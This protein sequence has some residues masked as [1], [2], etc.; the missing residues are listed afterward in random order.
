MP[1][2]GL[3]GVRATRT[4]DTINGYARTASAGG[5]V[6]TPI[7]RENNFNDFLPNVSARIRFLPTL[8]MRLAYTKTRTRAGFGQLNPSV[9]IGAAPPI[10][11]VDPANPD[12]GPNNPDCIR[13]ASGGNPDLKPIESNN[14]DASV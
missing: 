3:I 11:T 2:D 12:S 4:E 14:Y 13:T 6:V 7:V 5:T 1:I 10:C 8:Q 9:T